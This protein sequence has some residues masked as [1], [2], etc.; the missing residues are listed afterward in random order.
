MTGG[1]D[2][3]DLAAEAGDDLIRDQ[4]A[5][6]TFPSNDSPAPTET[7]AAITLTDALQRFSLALP[8]AKVW[9]AIEC[10]LLKQRAVQA[11][12]GKEIFSQWL[13]HGTRATVR[14]DDVLASAAAAQ[15]KGSGDLAA[16]LNRYIYLYPSSEVW[17]VKNRCMIPVNALKVAI[18]DV[19]DQ[20]VKH[21]RR[22]QIN[23]GELVFD[24]GGPWEQDGRIN[25]FRGMPLKPV[26][27]L[28]R[29]RNI[30]ALI[31]HLCNEDNEIFDWLTR[32]LALPLQQV[33][34]KLASAVI[35]HSDVQGAGKSLFF[36]EVMRKI[37][38]EYGATLGQHQMESQYTEWRSQVLYALFEEIFSREQKYSHIGQI[39][40]MVSGQTHRLE[41][42]YVS[43]WEEANHMNAVFLSNEFLPMPI[44]PADRRMLVVWPEKKL[45][46]SLRLGVLDDI[47]NGG[48]KAFYGW[49]LQLDMGDF[50]THRE[51]P[52]TGA[53]RRLIDFGRPGWDLFHRDWAA[54]DLDVPYQTCLVNDLYKA[55][56]QWC[57]A[58]GEK[59]VVSREKFSA[60]ISSKERRVRDAHFWMDGVGQ[61][62]QKGTFIKIGELPDGKQ[63][64]DWLGECVVAFRKNL[65][66]E[67]P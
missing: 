24:P 64:A 47:A 36:D 1:T 38:G 63:Q 28:D 16:A 43:S 21:P 32:W 2:F 3:N 60:F 23:R 66:E 39:K 48:I 9:D 52:I 6:V 19:Y 8:D 49:L 41:Q 7:L 4:L 42:K 62:K 51:P 59:S 29:C 13:N 15:A 65:K 46:E 61:E 14:Q 40:H 18:A 45:P 17:D 67:N 5:A 57:H 11:W 22:R 30:R 54:G 35:M 56:K 34:A 12:W 53:K 44:E 55:Y 26:N 37:Y 27:D 31:W 33:G 50:H 25:M 58:A 20:W 10:K